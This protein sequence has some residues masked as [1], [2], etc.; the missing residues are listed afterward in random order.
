MCLIFFDFQGDFLYIG[1]QDQKLVLQIYTGGDSYLSISSALTYNDNKWHTIVTER[2]NLDGT[3][4]MAALKT[5]LLTHSPQTNASLF[6]F[7]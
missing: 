2:A 3:E 7:T 5:L 4:T 1:I 6:Q